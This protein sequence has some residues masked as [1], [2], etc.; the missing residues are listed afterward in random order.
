M[1]ADSTGSWLSNCAVNGA[2]VCDLRTTFDEQ[3]AH[4]AL[5]PDSTHS[6]RYNWVSSMNRTSQ[7][8]LFKSSTKQQVHVHPVFIVDLLITY[9]PIFTS[10]SPPLSLSVSIRWSVDRWSSYEFFLLSSLLRLSLYLHE[11]QPSSVGDVSS[12]LCVS[13]CLAQCRIKQSWRI[14]CHGCGMYVQTF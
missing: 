4:H 13:F 6:A 1:R 5:H 11:V 8:M 3:L 12:T 9:R 14:D 2:P 7:I 10:L